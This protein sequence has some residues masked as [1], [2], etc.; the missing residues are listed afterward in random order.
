MNTTNI[1]IKFHQPLILSMIMLSTILSVQSCDQY[2]IVPPPIE[3]ESFSATIQP[4][5]NNDCV[6]CHSGSLDPNLS[7]GS[8]YVSLTN[9]GYIDTENPE[10]S[11]LYEML[12][13]AH[14]GYTSNANEDFILQ[15]ITEGAPND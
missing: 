13:G 9:G 3:Y 10:S 1:K 14:S 7:A 6:G 12:Q 8:A 11:L 2:E 15:W 5:F 4:I